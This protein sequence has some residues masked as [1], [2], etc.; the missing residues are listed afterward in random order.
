MEVDERITK[1]TTEYRNREYYFCALECKITLEE[2]PK[3]IR[4]EENA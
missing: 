3:S 4:S 1:H 2:D